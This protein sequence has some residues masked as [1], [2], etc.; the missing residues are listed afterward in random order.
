ERALAYEEAEI[1]PGNVV[2]QPRTE[3]LLPPETENDGEGLTIAGDTLES[4]SG[5]LDEE[6][7]LDLESAAAEEEM[8]A[9]DGGEAL[10][11]A[12]EIPEVEGI[13]EED[14]V[15]DMADED[16]LGVMGEPKETPDDYEYAE[17]PTDDQG[18]GD[19][20]TAVPPTDQGNTSPENGTRQL[21]RIALP[22]WVP[23]S[24]GI[25]TL[26][27][28]CFTYLFNRRYR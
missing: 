9:L 19:L 17:L 12:P 24:L 1:E 8:T 4:D 3:M 25:L 21:A 28:L 27:L 6:M 15:L 2:S 13:A 22:Q 14:P 10:P 7:R 5:Q 18:D 16:E 23:A 20:L 26:L 11:A